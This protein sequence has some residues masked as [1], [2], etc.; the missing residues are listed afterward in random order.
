MKPKSA[1]AYVAD[2]ERRHN[3]SAEIRSCGA[4]CETPSARDVGP[5]EQVPVREGDGGMSGKG[6]RGKGAS[7]R[8]NMGPSADTY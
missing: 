8:S 1:A 4:H 2:I 6:G 5:K 3:M 7:S